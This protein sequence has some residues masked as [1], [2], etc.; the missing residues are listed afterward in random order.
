MSKNAIHSLF[1]RAFAKCD[2]KYGRVFKCRAG[3]VPFNGLPSRVAT[4]AKGLPKN[5]LLSFVVGLAAVT[6]HAEGDTVNREYQLKTAYL[7]H[8]AELA[9]WPTSL[10][11][12]ICLQGS[13]PLRNYLP[14][15]EAQLIGGK[16]VHVLRVDRQDNLS[17]C[18]ILFLSDIAALSPS[19]IEQARIRHILLVSD[20]DGFAE[21][22][23]MVQFALRDNKLKLVINLSAVK[24]A[25]LKFSSKLLRMAEILE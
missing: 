2:A 11:V 6:C 8:F 3:A 20:V 10:P 24:Q 16:A 7:F 4:A 17:D 21:Q 9:E 14:A 12:T 15:L 23:G 18:R 13:S 19:L 5:M 25:G 22:G 1:H